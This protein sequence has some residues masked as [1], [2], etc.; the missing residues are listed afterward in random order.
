MPVRSS[1]SKRWAWARMIA[2]ELGAHDPVDEA[3]VVLD[4]GRQH[5]LAAGLVAGG[6]GL[7]LDDERLELGPGGVEG[8]GQ[9]GRPAADDDD[10]A[11]LRHRAGTPRR[12]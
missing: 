4:L 10:L 2:H 12:E 6:R 9:A 8:G 1:A 3:G 5:E 11:A 7:A